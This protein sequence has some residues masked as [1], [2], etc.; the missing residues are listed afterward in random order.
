MVYVPQENVCCVSQLSG[1]EFCVL[2]DPQPAS[3]LGAIPVGGRLFVCR[4]ETL[5]YF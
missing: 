5:M 2:S 3:I 1:G 4:D